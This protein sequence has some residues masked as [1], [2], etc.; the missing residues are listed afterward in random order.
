MNKEIISFIDG[1]KANRQLTSFEVPAIKQSVVMKLLFMLGWDIFNLDE[2]S[3]NFTA[4]K[5][6]VDF[7]LKIN[8]ANKI[9]INVIKADQP[10]VD[11]APGLCAAASRAK[12]EFCVLTNGNQWL[13]YLTSDPKPVAGNDFCSLDLLAQGTDDVARQLNEFLQKDQLAQ[14]RALKSAQKLL[15]ERS[16][17]RVEEALPEAWRQILSAPHELLVD[18]LCD[19]TE[20]ICGFRPEKKR[21]A[22]FL[23]AGAPTPGQSRPAQADALPPV[24][25]EEAIL[26]DSFE[27]DRRAK[28]AAPS[29]EDKTLSS[30]LF[31]KKRYKIKNWGDLVFKLCEVLK[32]EHGQD[33][34]KLL[35]HPVR[36]K[37]Y[38]SRVESELRFPENIDGTD[39]FVQTHMTPN[40]AVRVAHSVLSFYGYSNDDFSIST[41]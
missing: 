17:A 13:F 30:F 3:Q 19:T 14:G 5:H 4:E 40:E 32:S 8:G 29:Y 35:W 1:L 21:A 31:K 28:P 24:A 26:V 25:G 10:L 37:Y 23:S 9:F 36:D 11:H 39:I 22:Q 7:C 2:V 34:E 6:P 38:F 15:Q 41:E 20:K 12:I 18:L 33:I 27:P 16:R